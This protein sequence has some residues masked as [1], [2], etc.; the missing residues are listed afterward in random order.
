MNRI[1]EP[2]RL[3]IKNLKNGNRSLYLDIY[4]NGV[5]KYEFLNL[6]LIPERSKADKTVNESTMRLATSIKAKRTVAIQNGRYDFSTP[7]TDGEAD[8]LKYIERYGKIVQ[9]H[10][11][12]SQKRAKCVSGKLMEYTGKSRLPMKAVDTDFLRG[13]LTFLRTTKSVGG[14][15]KNGKPKLLTTNTIHTYFVFLVAVLKRAYKDRLIVC[16]PSDRLYTEERTKKEF[17]QMA[18]LTEEEFKALQSTRCRNQYVADIFTFSCLTGLR[19]S[20]VVSLMW[21]DVSKDEK[22][23][24]RLRKM[25]VKTVHVVEFPLPPSAVAIMMKYKGGDGLVFGKKFSHATVTT[26]VRNWCRAAGISKHITFHSARH[27][28]ATLL[29]TKG[30]DLYTVS[31]LLG[32]TNIGSTQIY[33][34]VVEQSKKQA[35]DL[36]ESLEQS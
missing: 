19:Y 5:R 24:Y 20:D 11:Q 9:R 18:Y 6:Y 22:G 35:I 34:E 4:I 14:H 28:F 36:L 12:A 1:K 23:T 16:D 31:K 30:A 17:V 3:R 21:S 26:Q 13:F 32:H 33:A 2:V 15:G 27:T 25:Q 8:L 10:G 29:L 7:V